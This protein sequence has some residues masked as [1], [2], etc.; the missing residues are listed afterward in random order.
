MM[1]FDKGKKI[2]I[3]WIICLFDR[4]INGSTSKICMWC[5]W[6]SLEAK[7]EEYQWSENDYRPPGE[8]DSETGQVAP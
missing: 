5:S 1:P 4:E 2:Q 8:S 3:V 6:C 7:D